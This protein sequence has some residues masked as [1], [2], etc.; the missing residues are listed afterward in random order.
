MSAWLKTL[1][2]WLGRQYNG[3]EHEAS[4]PSP[5]V[6]DYHPA[7]GSDDEPQALH[8]GRRRLKE[9]FTSHWD[10]DYLPRE[11]V[12]ELLKET[13]KGQHDKP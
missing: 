5:P 1:K 11:E 10:L 9:N 6:P 12:E 7:H 13:G 8:R 2:R 3:A 4:E